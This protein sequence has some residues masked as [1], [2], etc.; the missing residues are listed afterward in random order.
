M[1]KQSLLIACLSL[2]LVISA[3][4][5]KQESNFTGFHQ[6]PQYVSVPLDAQ[7]SA[8][9]LLA[10]RMVHAGIDFTQVKILNSAAGKH[11]YYQ[12]EKNEIPFYGLNARVHDYPNGLASVQYPLISDNYQGDFSSTVDLEL[13]KN[14]LKATSYR[15][16]HVYWSNQN[17]NFKALR[18]DYYGDDG[19]H[20]TLISAADN[21]LVL[22]DQRRYFHTSDS[23]CTALIF[24]PDPLSTANVNY[25]GLYVD[26]NDGPVAVL[27]AERQVITFKADFNNGTFRLEN[28]DLKISDFS[29]PSI[30]PYIQTSPTFTLG[31]HQDGFEDVNAFAHLSI[32]KKYIDSL[33]FSSIPGNRIEIDVHALSNTDNSYYSPSELKI[34][35]GEGGVDDA[36]DVDVVIHEYIHTLVFGAAAN[37]SRINERAGMEEAICDYFAV[38]YSN[39]YNTNQSDRV[40]NWDGHNEFWPGRNA[41][42]IK[43][44]QTLIFV[45]IYANTDL[46][47]SCLREILL[48]TSRSVS[49]QII[50][51]ALFSLQSSSTYRDFALMVINADQVLNGGQNFSIIK[52]A[53][54]RRNVLDNQFFSP[55][56]SLAE[57]SSFTLYNSFEFASGGSLFIKSEEKLIAYQILSLDGKLIQQGRLSG[58]Q[59]EVS[60]PALKSGLYLVIIEGLYSTASFKVFRN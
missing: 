48:N 17:T 4:N 15:S 1:K 41:A 16:E 38:S 36:E 19:L 40:F 44:Y 60:A 24:A 12:I 10:D 7:E 35:M 23:T 59:D 8:L 5:T 11:L 2:S 47:V 34:Y 55:E 50:L 29:A 18:T 51:E 21:I 20:Y 14:D 3:Q 32:F 26:S 42:S 25:G 57:T 52:D 31:R 22:E 13:L 39:K 58:I 9:T 54:V 56:E 33:G 6:G 27:D 30:P 28:A 46:M 53:F 43:D 49:D 45:D 37:N